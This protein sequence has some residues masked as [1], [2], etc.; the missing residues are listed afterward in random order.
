MSHMTTSMVFSENERQEPYRDVLMS[1]PS[2]CYLSSS[3]QDCKGQN[4]NDFYYFLSSILS[5]TI[6]I[7]KAFFQMLIEINNLTI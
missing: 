4:N 3:M 6:R 5:S 7:L 2:H 1:Y